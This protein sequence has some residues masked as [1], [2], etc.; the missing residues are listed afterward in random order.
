MIGYDDALFALLQ[1]ARR[2]DAVSCATADALGKVLAADVVSPM[3]LPSFDHSA[4]DGYALHAGQTLAAG[5]E[6]AVHG[7]QAA[8]DAS[9]TSQ[10]MAWEIMTGRGCPRDSTPS[11]RSSAPSCWL[12]TT[13]VHRRACGYSTR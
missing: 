9:C 4:M 7:S 5:T 3:D 2:L 13:M 11:S 10:G 6:H 8:G 12:A 1:Q